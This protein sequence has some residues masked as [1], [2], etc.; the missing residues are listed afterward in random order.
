MI[1]DYELPMYFR[2]ASELSAA[3]RAG[4]AQRLA[5]AIDEMEVFA[6]HAESRKLAARAGLALAA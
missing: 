2:L 3:R 5:L 4:D 1:V 6:M